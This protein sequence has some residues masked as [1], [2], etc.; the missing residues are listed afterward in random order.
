[1][2]PHSDATGLSLLLQVNDV[3]GLQIKKNDKWVLVKPIS[4]AFIININDIIE[5]KW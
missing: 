5:V 4:S 2:T 1:I 3:Q